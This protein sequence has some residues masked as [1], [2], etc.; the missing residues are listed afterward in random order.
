LCE[1]DNKKFSVG[2]EI[3]NISVGSVSGNTNIYFSFGPRVAIKDDR[4]QMVVAQ[5]KMIS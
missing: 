3:V 1:I 5:F 2:T 4:D